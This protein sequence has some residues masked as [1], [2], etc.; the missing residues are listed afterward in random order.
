MQLCPKVVK[1]PEYL[2]VSS[3]CKLIAGDATLRQI[4]SH[5]FMWNITTKLRDRIVN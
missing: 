5:V 1:H 2:S 4:L 3:T